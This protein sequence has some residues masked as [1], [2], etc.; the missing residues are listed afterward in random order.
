M[1]E[2]GESRQFDDLPAD[3]EAGQVHCFRMNRSHLDVFIY[4]VG[5]MRSNYNPVNTSPAEHIKAV[6]DRNPK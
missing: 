5:L 2:L 4:A 3:R 1:L 6:I